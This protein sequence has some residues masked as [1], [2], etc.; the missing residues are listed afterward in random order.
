M[1]IHQKHYPT[2]EIDNREPD[3]IQIW[4]NGKEDSNVVQVE[5]INVIDLIIKLR[6]ALDSKPVPGS[7]PTKKL[8]TIS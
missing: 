4:M 8:T 1:K 3:I 5:R 2:I 7:W 6:E